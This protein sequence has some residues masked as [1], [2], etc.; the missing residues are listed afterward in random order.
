MLN[1]FE[2]NTG[3]GEETSPGFFHK[4]NHFGST[5]L[6]AEFVITPTERNQDAASH[7][8]EFAQAG[9]HGA[10]GSAD[11]VCVTLLEKVQKTVPNQHLGW[12]LAR[13]ARTCNVTVKHWRRILSC[14]DGWVE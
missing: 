5:A 6:C 8:H 9:C 3:I 1:D 7:Q 12:K 10:I 11:A 2:E 13:T 14:A 4:F